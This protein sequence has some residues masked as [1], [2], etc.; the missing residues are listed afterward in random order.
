MLSLAR[1]GAMPVFRE[2]DQGQ[3]V[4][5]SIRPNELL[6]PDHPARVIDKVVEMLDLG[7]VYAD[8][9]EEGSPPYHPQMMLKVVFY[10]YYCGLMSSRKIW[11]G[12]KE[13]ADFIFLS[14]DQVPDF[15]TINDFRTR[16][17]KL[18]PKLFAQIVM[19]C[20]RLGMLDFQNLAID[21]EK[22]KASANYRRSKNRKRTK[23]SYQRVKEALARVVAKPVNEDFTAE[24]K[25]ARLERL[26]GQKKD[27][28]ALKAML[29]DMEDEEA[30]VN[31]TDPEAK[32]M[33]HKD[34]RSLP[35]Y[36]HQS[37][38]DGKMGVV[39]AVSTTDESDKP[40][41]LFSLVDRAKENAGQGHENVLADPG[42]CDYET[43]KQAECE[44]EEEYYLPD[45]R[46]EVTE[47]GATS[48]GK[49][50]S[51][52][53]EKKDGKVF[54]PE[55]K[56]MELK[57][58]NSL[59]EGNTVSIYEG[60]ECQNCP[61][62]EKCTKGKKRTIAVDSREPF[63]ERMRE[64]LRSDHGRETY[65]KRQGIVE[66]VHGD[67]QQNKGWRQHRLRWK[68]RR[69]LSSRWSELRRTWERSHDTG[70]WS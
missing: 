53:F 47:D 58:V 62:R 64:K 38:V 48:R 24:K 5:R 21:G 23:Q 37:A 70:R 44:R 25:A 67:D 33:K 56:P 65:M 34:G 20:V 14:G 16:H 4:F 6:E 59:G 42:F 50:D 49:Y 29:E 63:R 18:L 69:R 22:I 26:D 57:T 31:M 15:R 27:L 61:R 17:M 13:R 8:Y 39:V 40:A 66:P 2:Y 30:T 12:L 68:E 43:L 52:N 7:E 11:D 19:I 55:G 36:N 46:F 35:S 3:G 51:S 32:V 9:A 10:A 45:R 60:Q 28:L 41:D 1:E 54:C